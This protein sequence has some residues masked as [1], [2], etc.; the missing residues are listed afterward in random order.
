MLPIS[1]SGFSSASDNR[2]KNDFSSR[3]GSPA[4]PDEPDFLLLAQNRH[5][6]KTIESF[7]F[8]RKEP[9]GLF[10]KTRSLFGA[11]GRAATLTVDNRVT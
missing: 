10:E 5:R 7:Y 2:H 3:T 6:E 11:K 9:A 4:E 1:K 8:P